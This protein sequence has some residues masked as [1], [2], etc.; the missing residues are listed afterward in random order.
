[1]A[2]TRAIQNNFTGGVFSPK[3]RARFDFVKYGNALKELENFRIFP[4]GGATRRP[5]SHYVATSKAGRRLIPFVISRTLAYVLELGDSY[6]RFYR[7]EGQL[8]DG[9]SPV[10]ISTPWSA[11]E[12]L[13]LHTARGD[14]GLWF[15][16]EDHEPRLLVRLSDTDWELRTVGFEPAPSREIGRRAAETLTLSATTGNGVTLTAASNTLRPTDVGRQL[17]YKASRAT[18]TAWNSSTQVTVDIVV[19]FP[20]TTIP[21]NE[22]L[23]SG[24]PVANLFIRERQPVGGR[25]RLYLNIADDPNVSELL[26]NGNF[27]TDLS[28]W[29]DHSGP[30][31]FTGEQTTGQD[32]A[33]I[34]VD[35]DGTNLADAG[36][37]TGHIA[38][39]TT[40]GSADVVE[41]L[42]TGDALLDSVTLVDGLAGG[43]DNMFQGGDSVTFAQ[44]GSARQSSSGGPSRAILNGGPA[45]IAWIEQAEGGLTG[46]Y[47]WIQFQVIDAPLSFMVGSSSQA[48]D[49]VP[50]RT[51]DIGEHEVFF[52]SSSAQ[53]FIQFR[54]NQN[55]DAAVTNISV[56]RASAADW[57]D[58]HLGKYVK[59]HGG[60]IELDKRTSFSFIEG[61]V[62]KALETEEEDDIR[63]D[64]G[65]WTLEDAVWSDAEGW[66]TT[67][68]FL[69]GRLYVARGRRIWG[70][71]LF[72]ETNFAAGVND[73]DSLEFELAT[74]DQE[75]V[76]WMVGEEGL[77]VGTTGSEYV[78]TGSVGGAITPTSVEAISPSSSGSDRIQAVKGVRGVFFVQAGQRAIHTMSAA[79]DEDT[80]IPLRQDVSLL[81]EDQFRDGIVGLAYQNAPDPTLWVIKNDGHLMALVWLPTHDIIAWSHHETQGIIRSVAVIPHPDGDRDQV[82]ILVDRD[83]DTSGNDAGTEQALVEYLDDGNGWYGPL[84]VDSGL[85]YDGS[86]TTTLTGLDHLE[87]KEVVILGDGSNMGTATVQSGEIT[88][89]EEVERAEVGLAFTP[90][91]V[92][93]RPVVDGVPVSGLRIANGTITVQVIDTS[94]LTING[95]AAD[96]RAGDD[97]MDAPIPLRDL[98]VEANSLGW[99]YDAEV[100]L[101]VDQPL[102][103]TVLAITRTLEIENA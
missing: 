51:Y 60:I 64:V 2:R 52:L 88:T 89:P 102:P 28:S 63:A 29:T 11:A 31:I 7:N 34:F 54:N 56:K 37:R 36:V 78:I 3:V 30:A 4:Q 57:R 72:N 100:E 62:R 22:W 75:A 101:R 74:R 42:A 92:T 83:L 90:R 40:D 99:D 93:L 58:V 87:G 26:A 68:T 55:V 1:M 79:P 73:N 76:Q 98:D 33:T 66:P 9:G 70:S 77:L 50:E 86:A 45:G 8:V 5:G 15:F 16:H 49:V 6:M 44:T 69:S 59:V 46:V 25:V 24:S 48:S 67:G 47:G 17:E 94:A 91:L 85:V 38:N 43:S 13:E 103:C 71:R 65:T 41:S 35:A 23:L 97:L 82:W 19:D 80:V 10:E 18:I 32:S 20:S 95:D 81:A 53:V 27:A 84:M 96:F 21:A 61:I 39:N 14:E 12:T